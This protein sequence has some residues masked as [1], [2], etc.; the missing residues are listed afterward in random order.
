[1]D[2]LGPLYNTYS[3]VGYDPITND[4]GI[5]V[6][7][8]YIAVG[9]SVPF[10]KPEVG[11]LAIQAYANP[12]LGPEGL[13]LLEKGYSPNETIEILMKKDEGKDFRQ[14]GIVD[15]K[16]HSATY[17][18]KKC[19][20]WAGGMTE[21][22]CAAQGNMLI[23]E[24]TVSAMIKYFVSHSGNLADR[25]LDS[26]IEGEQIGG[27]KRGRQSSALLVV[28]PNAGLAVYNNNLIDLRVDSHYSPCERLK[29][30]LKEYYD[31]QIITKKE[32]FVILNSKI[33]NDMQLALYRLGRYRGKIDGKYN[34][35]TQNAL[36]SFCVVENQKHRWTEE[37]KIDPKLYDILIKFSKK[38]YKE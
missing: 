5:A 38:T 27:D 12:K 10:A 11:A 22:Y 16:G 29:E 25:L 28:R 30:L 1:M 7:T 17:T 14:L 9:S 2:N 36:W 23:G 33:I 32:N 24:S 34:K 31:V 37:S 4:L 20:F 26:L 21:Q 3:I 6:A 19:E 35:Q 18:G 13:Q 8:K 15:S